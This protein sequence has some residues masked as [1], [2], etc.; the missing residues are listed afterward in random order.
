MQNHKILWTFG[1][2]YSRGSTLFI[3]KNRRQSRIIASFSVLVLFALTYAIF[4]PI[5]VEH[6]GA[7]AVTGSAT[8]ATTS[9]TLSTANN[10]ASMHVVPTATGGTFVSSNAADS[11]VFN[12]NTNNYTGL[13]AGDF[14]G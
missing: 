3:I 9:L 7:Y 8:V 12:V 6:D 13:Y 2:K 1:S 10:L 14:F 5:Y 11:A 4:N